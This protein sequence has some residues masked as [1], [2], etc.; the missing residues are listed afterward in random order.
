MIADDVFKVRAALIA[1]RCGS[2]AGIN[3]RNAI[4]F[5]LRNRVADPSYGSWREALN[6]ANDAPVLIPDVRE[7]EFQRLLY[8]VESIYDGTA[9]DRLTNGAL[10]WWN[11]NEETCILVS[12]Q[13][14]AKIP[15]LIFWR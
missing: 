9:R 11:E 15:P 8:D 10:N 5:V 3:G 14:V 13:I 6:R 4:L 12:G 7:P 1:W 2:A